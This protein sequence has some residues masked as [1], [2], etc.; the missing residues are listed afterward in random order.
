[1][2]KVTLNT[3]NQPYL[4]VWLLSSDRLMHL[5]KT[6]NNFMLAIQSYVQK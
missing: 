1:L 6:Y 2:L 4:F 3:T 5:K